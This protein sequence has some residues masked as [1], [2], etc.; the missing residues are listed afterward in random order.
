MSLVAAT[1]ALAL[2]A[3]ACSDAQDA[4]AYGSYNS[5][6]A[7]GMTFE[8]QRK[9]ETQ[10]SQSSTMTI[11]PNYFDLSQLPY[12]EIL[13]KIFPDATTVLLKDDVNNHRIS[14][15]AA[16][17]DNGSVVYTVQ[18]MTWNLQVETNGTQHNIQI[19]VA[20]EAGN[21]DDM[22][23]GTL[24]GTG[25]MTLILHVTAYRT[26]GQAAV[27]MPMRLTYTATRQ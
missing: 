11:Y 27:A 12:T 10:A 17:A 1:L 20:P 23:W 24:S 26:D 19:I 14:Y 8:G 5:V 18:P 7:A 9:V 4:D 3:T 13:Q 16:S 2:C 22:S 25:V 15:R 6:T 21:A